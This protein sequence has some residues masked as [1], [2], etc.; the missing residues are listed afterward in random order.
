MGTVLT[1]VAFAVIVVG[2]LA[3]GIWALR[4]H[5]RQF[6]K[7]KVH[8]EEREPSSIESKTTWLSGGRG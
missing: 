8:F 3:L 7:G 4:R 5:N 2:T 6:P 1:L